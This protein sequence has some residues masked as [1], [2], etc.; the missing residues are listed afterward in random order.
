MILANGRVFSSEEQSTVLEQMEPELNETLA[1]KP[2]SPEAVIEAIGQLGEKIADG[3][4]DERIRALPLE[5]ADRLIQEMLPLLRRESLAYKLRMELGE[6]PFGIQRTAP[7]LGQ[8]PM[9]VRPMPLGTLLHIAAGNI[10]GLPAFSVVEGLLT[11][12]I[13]ILKLPQ[14]DNG[15]SLQILQELIRIEPAL[16][17]YIYVFDT[18]SSDLPGLRRM[19]DFCDGIVVWGGDEAVAAVQ[20]FAPPGVRLI[21]WG[22]KLGFAY[23]SAFENQ[24]EDLAALALHILST[25]QLLCS[26][27]QTIYIDTE[28][29]EELYTFCQ[30]FLPILEAAAVDYPTESLGAAAEITL[31]RYTAVLESVLSGHHEA[32]E[33]VFQGR[34]CSLKACCDSRLELSD[35]F[36]NCLVKRL[37]RSQLLPCLRKHKGYLQTAGLICPEDQ[38]EELTALLARCGVVR[39]TR[40]GGMSA[41]FSGEAHDGEYPLRRYIRYVNIE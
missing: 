20:N 18:P 41:Y 7:P 36:G 15:V 23:L 22:H 12:N 38:R 31:R 8:K 25:N 27:C 9:T 3:V 10:D 5:G 32:P 35:M 17:P 19:A 16:A 6:E 4:F 11:G 39:V 28:D 33:R 26:S 37:P 13:N 40:G 24:Q 30:A 29:M 21:E 34:R 14:A 1:A 2:L